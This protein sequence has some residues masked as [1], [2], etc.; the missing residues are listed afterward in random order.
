MPILFDEKVNLPKPKEIFSFLCKSTG[1]PKH[2]I[3]VVFPSGPNGPL[4]GTP[5]Y[6]AGVKHEAMEARS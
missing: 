4:V 3:V 1:V 2:G 6:R 5:T